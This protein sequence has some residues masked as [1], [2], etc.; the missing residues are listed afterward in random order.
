[1]KKKIMLALI[2][3]IIFITVVSGS[4]KAS[5]GNLIITEDAA[6]TVY[7]EKDAYGNPR[8]LALNTQSLLVYARDEKGNSPIVVNMQLKADHTALLD[9]DAYNQVLAAF[10]KQSGGTMYVELGGK[11][12]MPVLQETCTAHLSG[13]TYTCRLD[14]N[15]HQVICSNC[16]KVIKKEPHDWG[17]N[18]VC[19]ACQYRKDGKYS[20]DVKQ[21]GEG[22]VTVNPPTEAAPGDEVTI[23]ATPAEGYVLKRITVTVTDANGNEIPIPLEEVS[24]VSLTR[25][26][27]EYV[28]TAPP[29]TLP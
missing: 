8:P 9:E 6:H 10:K 1:M 28:F 4:S 18:D 5:A 21:T 15:Y 27:D 16:D 3:V 7:I 2:A 22:I 26:G 25:I 14:E 19:T 13:Q 29:G 23:T 11:E 24:N 17:E 20:I 12:Y